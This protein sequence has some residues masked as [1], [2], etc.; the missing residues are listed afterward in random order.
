MTT[1][2]FPN[3]G[4]RE[5][6]RVRDGENRDP[7]HSF[8]FILSL[9]LHNDDLSPLDFL[10]LTLCVCV[11]WCGVLDYCV[12]VCFCVHYVTYGHYSL[13]VKVKWN[14]LT[15]PQTHTHTQTFIRSSC[16]KLSNKTLLF[17]HTQSPNPWPNCYHNWSRPNA[18][19]DHLQLQITI[20]ELIF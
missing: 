13:L 20:Q 12:Y 11:V 8:F 16:L 5:K 19:K 1:W 7:F 15:I 10:F 9:F 2:N 14:S 17:T 3:V 4:G 18:E 6:K